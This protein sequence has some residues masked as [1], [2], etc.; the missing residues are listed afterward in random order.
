ML[1]RLCS[2]PPESAAQRKPVGASSVQ[3]PSSVRG[4]PP[5]ET[6][7]IFGGRV[8]PQLGKDGREVH[9]Q[10]FLSSSHSSRQCEKVQ[11]FSLNKKQV[12]WKRLLAKTH[13][14]KNGLYVTRKGEQCGRCDVSNMSWWGWSMLWWRLSPDRD[15][16]WRRGSW[17]WSAGLTKSS[18]SPAGPRTSPPQWWA[19]RGQVPTRQVKYIWTLKCQCCKMSPLKKVQG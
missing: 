18:P 4:A 6:L 13:D 2:S 3:R 11:S 17:S 19:P 12:S 16:Q 5:G 7:G 10:K 9:N 15:R 8:S 14:V 1:R